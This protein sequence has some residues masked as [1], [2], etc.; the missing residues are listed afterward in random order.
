MHDYAYKSLNQYVNSNQN[1]MRQNKKKT[2]REKEMV[3]Q[4]IQ[5]NEERSEMMKTKQQIQKEDNDKKIRELNHTYN[6]KNLIQ[7]DIRR[8]LFT[9]MLTKR[10]M[11]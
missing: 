3:K 4:R 5:R 8:E 2:L 10:E 1:I 11:N 7:S 6:K 9:Q